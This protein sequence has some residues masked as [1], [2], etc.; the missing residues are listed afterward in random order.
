MLHAFEVRQAGHAPVQ[1]AI[2]VTTCFWKSASERVLT[3]NAQ[4][5][6]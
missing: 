2:S 6:S 1:Y 4:K 3:A 5:G